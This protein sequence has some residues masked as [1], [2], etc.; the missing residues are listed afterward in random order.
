MGQ[1]GQRRKPPAARR[2]AVRHAQADEPVG[3]RT[4][5]GST[6][7]SC[8]RQPNRRPVAAEHEQLNALIVGQFPSARVMSGQKQIDRRRTG[9]H[10]RLRRTACGHCK[11]SRGDAKDQREPGV[12]AP[13]PV[14]RC[15]C[16][17]RAGRRMTRCSSP[18]VSGAHRNGAADAQ[19]INFVG[20]FFDSVS[21][22]YA[23]DAEKQLLYEKAPDFS[24]LARPASPTSRRA[25]R[26]RPQPAAD[27]VVAGAAEDTAAG[28]RPLS[29]RGQRTRA[30]P[31]GNVRGN[32]LS[33]TAGAR[34]RGRSE[35]VEA[36]CASCH[37]FGSVGTDHGVAS[38]NPRRHHCARRRPR[39]SKRS[40]SRTASSRRNTKRRQSKQPTGKKSTRSC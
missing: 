20:Q 26:Q 39:S 34:R 1:D 18:R 19:F 30:Q 37:K 9:T 38:L 28:R 24:P 8:T 17:N 12:A 21:N 23:S 7:R 14:Q 40:S 6:A 31:A 4:S 3:R 5:C 2:Q 32:G 15:G 27:G 16:S 29:P 22:L 25:R 36:N 10:A 11:D 35:G 13:L 33:A